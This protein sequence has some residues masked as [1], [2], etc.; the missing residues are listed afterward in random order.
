MAG[1]LSSSTTQQT[2]ATTLS[3]TAVQVAPLVAPSSADDAWYDNSKSAIRLGA[4]RGAR[5]RADRGAYGRTAPAADRAAN[6]RAG[7][8]RQRWRR[9]AASCALALIGS[10]RQRRNTNRAQELLCA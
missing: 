9:R 10:G 2:Y 4:D 3:V 6:H 1:R 7:R 8:T 5:R